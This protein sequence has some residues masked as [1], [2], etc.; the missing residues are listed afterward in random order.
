MC[1]EGKAN[2]ETCECDELEEYKKEQKINCYINIDN[3]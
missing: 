3:R 1:V 2:N